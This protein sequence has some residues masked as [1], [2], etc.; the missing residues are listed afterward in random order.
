MV[1]SVK[2][3]TSFLFVQRE[4]NYMAHAPGER[5]FP[6]FSLKSQ[7]AYRSGL[8]DRF[9]QHRAVDALRHVD[10]EHLASD[11]SGNLFI[12][13]PALDWDVAV[14]VRL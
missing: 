7:A 14:A 5:N 13:L 1:L 10:H 8:V 11:G 3:A 9:P 4:E 12:N 2:L 6:L